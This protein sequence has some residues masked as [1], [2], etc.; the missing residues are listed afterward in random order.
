M[1]LALERCMKSWH[2]KK[3]IG[4]PVT[5]FVKVGNSIITGFL[6]FAGFSLHTQVKKGFILIWITY[7]DSIFNFWPGILM[8]F[9]LF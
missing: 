2:I 4:T 1:F 3:V 7:K 8:C 5:K 9:K 6:K